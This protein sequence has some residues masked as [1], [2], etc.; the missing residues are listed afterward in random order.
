MIYKYEHQRAFFQSSFLF[1]S[2]PEGD[3]IAGMAYHPLHPV[4]LRTAIMSAA[5]ES[6]K[7]V[8]SGTLRL[9]NDKRRREGKSHEVAVD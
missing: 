9:R 7:L 5:R 2:N 4:R 8:E 3:P 1:L 6:Q